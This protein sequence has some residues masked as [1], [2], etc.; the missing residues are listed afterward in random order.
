MSKIRSAATAA[1]CAIGITAGA[2]AMASPAAALGSGDALYDCW[3]G[4]PSGSPTY[5]DNYVAFD[6]SG[7]HLT[8]VTGITSPDPT[9]TIA[10]STYSSVGPDVLI[11]SGINSTSLNPVVLEKSG[12]TATYA[13][14]PDKIVLNIS[15]GAVVNCLQLGQTQSGFP[16]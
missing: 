13:D 1:A 6:R 14:A 11:E 3:L 15:N 16:L 8:L 4:T 10:A 5:N 7:G 12:S 2:I 9:V